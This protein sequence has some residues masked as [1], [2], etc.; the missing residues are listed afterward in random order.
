MNKTS[1][2]RFWA[3][4]SIALLVAS[5]LAACRAPNVLSLSASTPAATP[6]ATVTAL[7]A[8]SKPVALEPVAPANELERRIMGVYQ[9]A[10]PSVVNITNRGYGYDFFMQPVPEEGSGSGFIYDDAGHVVTNYHVV[11]GAE[12][13]LVTLADGRSYTATVTGSDPSNDLAV[14]KIPTDNLP[15]PIPLGD[16]E[17][18]QVGQ[19]AIAIGNPFG[20][21]GTLTFGVISSL[22]RVIQSPDG[23]FIGE[24]IQTDASINPGNSGGPL[25]DLNGQVVGVN[26]QI[27]SASGASAGVG[28]AIPARTVQRVV[29]S[30]IA[31]GHYAHP[32][33]GI[34]MLDLTPARVQLFAQEDVKIPVDQGVLV[35][36][37]SP[38][39]PAAK[40][41]LQGG[42]RTVQIG[43]VEI[44]LGGDVITAINQQ[45]V[46]DS[47]GLTVYLESQTKVGDTVNLE[48]LHNGEKQTIP[49]VLGERPQGS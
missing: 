49:V 1:T 24:A 27:V 47:Q 4:L 48:I 44:P 30:L 18:L 29:P 14:V 42:Q 6:A 36:E 19:F 33:L 5:L 8:P 38:N 7:P 20:L 10:G 22:G 34:Q 32:W 15:A 21:Q 26:S 12:E 16:S 31:Q 2:K 37:T 9:T 35:I 41:G 28:F 43:N 11:E 46:S 25:L 40:A 23:R 39:G 13:L 45:P 17:Q 3:Y